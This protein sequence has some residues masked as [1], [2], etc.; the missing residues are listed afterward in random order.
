[1]PCLSVWMRCTS[2]IDKSR[3]V[4]FR[5]LRVRVQDFKGLARTRIHKVAVSQQSGDPK[6]TIS[7]VLSR[8]EALNRLYLCW[9]TSTNVGEASNALNS[10]AFSIISDQDSVIFFLKKYNRIRVLYNPLMG[11]VEAVRSKLD[12]EL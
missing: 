3:G 5:N 4:V 9:N 11:Q 2:Y 1:M 10:T 12:V 6:S 8:A 7:T